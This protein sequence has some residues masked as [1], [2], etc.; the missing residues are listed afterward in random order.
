MFLIIKNEQ[1][2]DTQPTDYTIIKN[3]LETLNLDYTVKDD[4]DNSDDLDDVIGVILTD[5]TLD[6]GQYKASI[7]FQH[8]LDSQTPVL[9]IGQGCLAL[10]DTLAVDTSADTNT[11]QQ[12]QI[13]FQNESVLFDFMPTEMSIVDDRAEYVNQIP[14]HLEATAVSSEQEILA[15]QDKEK[16]L[17]AVKFNPAHLDQQGVI[18]LENFIR[19]CGTAAGEL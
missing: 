10:A 11:Q 6:L 7:D 15:F 17:Y 5:D 14:E 1:N 4:L 16:D 9:G 12:K 19:Y 13:T 2:D 8:L 3:S 18:M